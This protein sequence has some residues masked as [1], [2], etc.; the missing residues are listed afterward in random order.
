M[1]PPE[2]SRY[3]PEANH[4]EITLHLAADLFWFRGHFPDQ[5]ILPG[6]AQL[7]WVMYYS[8]QLLATDYTLHS[9]RQ[10][11]FQAPLLPGDH[12]TLV[13]DWQPAS[14]LLIFSYQCHMPHH[15]SDSANWQQM[16]NDRP[17]RKTTS[18]GK[19]LLCR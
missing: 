14:Q 6:M 12:I 3:Q 13:L 18:N 11:K 16:S 1:M 10:L 8:Q 4:A 5:P 17:C 9:I 2:I 7:N 15:P 19:L